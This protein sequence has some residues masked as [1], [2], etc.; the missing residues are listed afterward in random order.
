MGHDLPGR[1]YSRPPAKASP[2]EPISWGIK[3]THSFQLIP[4]I[5]A[6]SIIYQWGYRLE[7][8]V[9]HRSLDGGPAW[10]ISGAVLV[11]AC[12]SD[13]STC[14]S[15]GRGLYIIIPGSTPEH[16]VHNAPNYQDCPSLVPCSPHLCIFATGTGDLACQEEGDSRCSTNWQGR[17]HIKGHSRPFRGCTGNPCPLF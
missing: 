17:N 7:W 4:W 5:V 11:H 10:A 9:T 3:V 16:L 2:W 1:Y 13:C 12:G 14:G 15:N 6:M 8:V